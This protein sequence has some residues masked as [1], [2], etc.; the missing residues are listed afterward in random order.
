MPKLRLAQ[1]NFSAGEFSEQLAA[2][3]D[4]AVYR[5]GAAALA[6]FR[7]HY[8]GGAESRFGT[9]Y[10][11]TL[12]FSPAKLVP[13]VFSPDQSYIHAFSNARD[14]IYDT[15][16]ALATSLTAAPWTTAMLARLN[17]AQQ[18]D[19]MIVVHPDLAMQAIARTGA[20]T[21]TR[22]AFAFETETISGNTKIKQ[23][24][25]KFA[26][27]TMTM[28][29]SATTGAGITL[30]LSA[31]GAFVTGGSGHTN[32]IV[33]YKQKQ[34]LVT[35]VASATSA[36]GT[37]IETL[38]G[39]TADVDWD[40]QVFSTVR[41]YAN[42]VVWHGDR[43]WFGGSKSHPIGLW[44]SRVGAYFNFDAGTGLAAE[45]IWE[46]APA[47]LLSEIR[48]LLD[49]RHLLVYGDRSLLYV[50]SAPDTPIKPDTMQIT[51]QQPYGASYVRPQNFD[52]AAAYVQSSG[53]VAREGLWVDTDQAYNA[54]QISGLA[55]HLISAPTEIAAFYGGESV[56]DES[57]LL[58]VNGNGNLSVFHSVRSEKMA[59]WVPWTTAGTFKAVCTTP[60]KIF[61]A[62]ERVLN[63]A[64]VWTLET[65]DE[66][67]A[68]LDCAL[69][70]TSGS[71]TKVFTGFGHLNNTVVDV[72][73]KGH[74][75][76]LYTPAGGTITLGA[77]DPEV[78]E[79]EAGFGYEPTFTPMPAD[80]DLQ[81]GAARGLKKRM[82]R[83]LLVVNGVTGLTV[84]GKNWLPDFQGDDFATVPVGKTGVIEMRLN[85]VGHEAQF[86]VT[87]PRGRKGTMLGLTRELYAG[88]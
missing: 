82:I 88:N 60:G 4:V 39:T 23:P 14:D 85:G 19:T 57:Y 53:L 86:D 11:A 37:V 40:E 13:F 38:P 43:L 74:Y 24:Y 68:P 33:R 49:F 25:F 78:T 30:T 47:S 87:I 35:A 15:A 22:A 52:G 16:G 59:A 69:R 8:Q 31:P 7:L 50:P 10:L 67:R 12:G 65:F 81:D 70:A 18:G 55:S 41:G 5:N 62:V 66:A 36:T 51:H 63:A 83:A 28:A 61:V 29:P 64:T 34:I 2:R 58:L 77:A 73:T 79:I 48:H 20:T 71:P 76:G 27:I 54:S 72:V 42:S 56:L 17:W 44:G 1:T 46:N 26:P 3:S 84:Q 6:N 75:L 80:F 32:T 21:F 9:R 45:A